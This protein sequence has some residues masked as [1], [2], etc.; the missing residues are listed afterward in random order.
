MGFLLQDLTAELC[1]LAYAQE[2]KREV[3][4]DKLHQQ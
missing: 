1:T 2:L 3:D 4:D